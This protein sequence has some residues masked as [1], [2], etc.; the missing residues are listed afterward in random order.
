[1]VERLNPQ[2]GY[3]AGNLAVLSQAAARAWHG[4]DVL[5]AVR[6]AR[7]QESGA[8]P[9]AG[10]DAGAWW[11]LAVLRSFATP[12]PFHDAARLP[13]A[14]MPPNRVRVLN[15]AQG[16]QVLVTR[17]FMTGLAGRHVA[18]SSPQWLPAHTLRHD[19]NLLFV[20][21]FA[22]RVLEAGREPRA[23]RQALEDAWLHERVQRRWQHLALS[24]GEGSYRSAAGAGRRSR[25]RRPHLE[26]R[27]GPGGRRLGA[28]APGPRR[29]R[30]S[31]DAR[32]AAFSRWRAGQ[33]PTCPSAI[34]R[35]WA[36]PS[37]CRTGRERPP[38]VRRAG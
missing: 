22:P 34:L 1:V 35:R 30:R 23:L 14:V 2:A 18:A 6:Q 38:P 10:L 19:F 32:T 20:G 33:S 24:L 37:S 26:P 9:A 13:L 36:C 21:A 3:A 5:A 17:L 28:G 15:A 16:L 7:A 12:L 25:P 8:A 11:R 27:G 4:L 31:G 29:S